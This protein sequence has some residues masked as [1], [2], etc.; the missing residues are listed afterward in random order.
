MESR[1]QEYMLRFTAFSVFTVSILEDNGCQIIG[2][3]IFLKDR[4]LGLY[5]FP[6]SVGRIPVVT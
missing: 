6:G 1:P 4:M 3:A 5:N 2:R